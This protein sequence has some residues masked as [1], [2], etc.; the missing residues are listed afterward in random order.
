M[1]D[2][3]EKTDVANWANAV[4]G[5]FFCSAFPLCDKW[6]SSRIETAL[7]SLRDEPNNYPG[8]LRSK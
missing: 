4:D 6:T 5:S 8:W 7:L 1:V 3:E 2:L